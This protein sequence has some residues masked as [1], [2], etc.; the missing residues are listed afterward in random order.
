MAKG[1]QYIG[2]FCTDDASVD[3]FQGTD[4]RG[5]VTGY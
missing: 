4:V 5:C 3:F 2:N 1:F